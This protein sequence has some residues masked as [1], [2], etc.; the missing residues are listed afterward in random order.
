MILTL[1][2]QKGGVGKSTIAWNLAIEFAKELPVHVIDLDMQKSLSA[3]NN[4]RSAN[5]LKPLT[6][7]S[8]SDENDFIA[9]IEKDRD[10]ELIIIDSGGFDSAFNRVAIMASDLLLTPVSDKPFDILG[11]QSY[12]EI[13][14]SLSAIA[15]STLSTHVI[16]NNLNPALKNYGDVMD[17][18]MMSDHFELMLSVLRQ[19]VD[20]SNSIGHGKSITEYRPQSKAAMEF[21]EL[22]NEISGKLNIK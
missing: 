13:L 2:H 15:K 3:A 8:F 10:D 19:R 1:S 14:A 9:F 11:L 16:F 20:F 22:K 12:E 6:I 17:F 21:L 4:I 5:E 18:V 7:H